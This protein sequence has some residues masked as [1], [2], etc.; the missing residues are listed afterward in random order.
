MR[1]MLLKKQKNAPEGG[2]SCQCLFKDICDTCS[3]KKD[4]G[5]TMLLKKHKDAAEGCLRPRAL[6][7]VCVCV[8][9]CVCVYTYIHTHIH[10]YIHTYIHI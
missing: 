8:C 2:R 3:F 10:T 5:D 9:V 1:H 4:K 7:H 6:W